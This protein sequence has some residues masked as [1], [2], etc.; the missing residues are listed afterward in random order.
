M[1]DQFKAHDPGK[2]ARLGQV[3]ALGRPGIGRMIDRLE[4]TVLS[5]G[6]PPV[7]T[8]SLA[9]GAA[10]G[11]R[12]GAADGGPGI[13]RARGTAIPAP[14]EGSVVDKVAEGKGG[15]PKRVGEPWVAAGVSRATWFRRK[16]GGG[17]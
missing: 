10:R 6:V 9:A 12:P 8:A 14:A 2:G 4:G 3:Q 1:A 17:V 7:R 5:H 15:R 11:A 13:S 16:K